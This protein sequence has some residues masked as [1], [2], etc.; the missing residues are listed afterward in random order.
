MLR[1]KARTALY[2]PG[3]TWK[4]LGLLSTALS[5][6]AVGRGRSMRPWPGRADTIRRDQQPCIEFVSR[7]MHMPF[8]WELVLYPIGNTVEQSTANKC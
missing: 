2:T 6:P 5:V 3:V 4:R 8:A 7:A 1:T